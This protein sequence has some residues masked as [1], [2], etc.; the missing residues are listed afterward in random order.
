VA[1]HGGPVS[2]LVR[3]TIAGS[4]LTVDVPVAV[5]MLIK[6]TGLPHQL[7]RLLPAAIPV[8]VTILDNPALA[9]RASPST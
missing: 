2:P 1:S 3:G 5:G 9:R 4:A 6:V 7:E 8:S